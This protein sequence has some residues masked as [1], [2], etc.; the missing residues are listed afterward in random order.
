MSITT[1]QPQPEKKSSSR[2]MI[3]VAL[4]IVFAAATNLYLFSHMKNMEVEAHT[5]RSQ[6]ETEIAKVHESSAY[7]S[8]Q[9]R[10]EFDELREQVK[11]AQSQITNKTDANTRARTQ[12][13]A[14][15]I[16]KKQREQQE[17][18]LG[19]IRT[20]SGTAG[21]AQQ[22]VEEVR[23]DVQIITSDA[24]ETRAQ[25]NETG[26]ALRS[27]RSHVMDLDGQV[28]SHASDIAKLHQLGERERIAFALMRSD[29][30]QRIGEIYLRLKST[31]P[32]NNRFTLEVL[33][34]DKTVEQKK[35][36]VHEA[37]R[38][39]LPGS[40]QPYDIVVTSVQKHQVNGYV[41]KSKVLAGHV[42]TMASR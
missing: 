38:F 27:T 36:H 21:E 17:M 22:G 9:A 24:E 37:M 29:R 14:D 34:D 32:K 35:K 7:R 41:S 28:N 15:T 42:A 11:K 19:E 31:S 26:S 16:A 6:L 5:L 33:A 39:Y 4:V 20:V 1:T 25:L 13:L 23:G 2:P 18:L 12:R 40:A 8:T 10:R 3:V 30:M